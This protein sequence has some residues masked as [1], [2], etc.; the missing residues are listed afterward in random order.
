MFISSVLCMEKKIQSNQANGDE[1][2]LPIQQIRA[3]C[4]GWRVVFQKYLKACALFRVPSAQ[5]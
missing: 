5:P 1:T 3:L 4:S 2:C